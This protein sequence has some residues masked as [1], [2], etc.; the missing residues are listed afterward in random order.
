MKIQAKT[1]GKLLI[2]AAF[3]PLVSLHSCREKEE[4]KEEQTVTKQETKEAAEA[5]TPA[6]T[7]SASSNKVEV[8]QLFGCLK[9]HVGVCDIMSLELCFS[10]STMFRVYV[11]SHE[12]D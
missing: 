4:K 9:I 12:A 1:F 8:H 6:S 5:P 10:S 11:S 2:I 3:V 7:S